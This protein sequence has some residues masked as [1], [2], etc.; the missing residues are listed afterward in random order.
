MARF[1]AERPDNDTG[2]M[3][4]ALHHS[5]NPLAKGGKPNRVVRQPAHGL[6]AVRLDIGFVHHVKTIAIAQT[7]PKGGVGIMRTADGIKIILLHEQNI[8]HHGLLV[9]GLPV[10]RAVFMAVDA[11]Y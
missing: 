2:M 3:T 8:L 4:V 1:V 6:H 5:G 11:A 7:I 9:H 10:G